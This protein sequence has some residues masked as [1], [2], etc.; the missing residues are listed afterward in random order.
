[1]KQNSSK[2][3]PSLIPDATAKAELVRQWAADHGYTVAWGNANVITEVKNELQRKKSLDMFNEEF[4]GDVVAWLTKPA[5]KANS[6]TVAIVVVPRPGHVVTFATES[7][8]IQGALPPGCVG[9]QAVID[10][11][12][13][14]LKALLAPAKIAALGTV[15]LK[16]LAVRLGAAKYG[17]TN[18]TYTPATGSCHMLIGFWI[19]LD[20][21]T[22]PGEQGLD[23]LMPECE[24]CNACLRAC[25]TGAL[26]TDRFLLHGERCLSY[27]NETTG[28]WPEWVAE[29]KHTALIDCL[30]CIRACPMNH[31]RL[32]LEPASERFT[33]DETSR[34][35]S[36]AQDR[37]DPVWQ[38]IDAKLKS[39]GWGWSVKLLSRN[40]KALARQS[41]G[42]AKASD[43]GSG[44]N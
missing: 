32:R 19:G 26:G 35:L 9:G 1:M 28:G 13:Q 34:I 22:W 24:G 40:L 5:Q 16:S 6:G 12:E 4:F 30:S 38:A 39:I 21:G 17:R 37:D 27:F 11:V 8:D 23:T 31:G 10:T 2:S 14:E 7:G 18:I 36:G 20:L 25:P 41:Q 15:P 44:N 3:K 29:S 42:I 43:A 33:P